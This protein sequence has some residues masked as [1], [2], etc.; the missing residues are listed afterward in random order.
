MRASETT[1]CAH[2]RIRLSSVMADVATAQ[3]G[4]GLD[5]T[6]LEVH[7]FVLDCETVKFE[8][9]MPALLIRFS[10]HIAI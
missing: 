2:V 5:G 1:S 4:I 9:V 10:M 3:H 7:S 6:G 8:T